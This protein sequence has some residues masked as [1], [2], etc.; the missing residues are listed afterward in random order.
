MSGVADGFG[1][2]ERP[3]S[4]CVFA[5][6]EHPTLAQHDRVDVGVHRGV[7]K[8]DVIKQVDAPTLDGFDWGRATAEHS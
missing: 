2:D 7:D 3:H 6:A 1:A 8:G 4:L 5:V